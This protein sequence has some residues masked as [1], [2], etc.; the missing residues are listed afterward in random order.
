MWFVTSASHIACLLCLFV[1]PFRLLPLLTGSRPMLNPTAPT[2][3]IRRGLGRRL[4]RSLLLNSSPSTSRDIS[5]SHL[6]ETCQS[7]TLCTK[8]HPSL[9]NSKALPCT[10]MCCALDSADCIMLYCPLYLCPHTCHF[11]VYLFVCLLLLSVSCVTCFVCLF[12]LLDCFL[13]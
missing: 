7:M 11:F 2:V 10:L 6:A 4:R 1:F 3:H 13:Y 9:I 5:L 12:S 8:L